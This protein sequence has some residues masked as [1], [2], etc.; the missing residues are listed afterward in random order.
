MTKLD[1]VLEKSSEKNIIQREHQK[2]LSPVFN[3]STILL[4]E[5]ICICIELHLVVL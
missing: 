3:Y 5:F 1:T 2:D 4:V